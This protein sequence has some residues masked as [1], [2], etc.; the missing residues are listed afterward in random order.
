MPTQNQISNLPFENYLVLNGLSMPDRSKFV[1]D[2]SGGYNVLDYIATRQAPARRIEG[3]DGKF[4]K[5]IMGV[6]VTQAVVAS[7][8]L[9]G[10]VLRVFFT[11]PTYDNFR[12]STVVGNGTANDCMGTVIAHAPGYVDVVPAPP[13]TAWNTSLHFLANS[14]ITEYFPASINRGSNALESQYEYPQYVINQ[15]SIIRDNLQLFRRDLSKTWVAYDGTDIWGTAQ[16]TIMMQR[17]ARSLEYRGLFSYYGTTNDPDGTRNFSMGLKASIKDPSR[18]GVYVASPSL[19][20]EAS[21]NNWI[22]EIADRRNSG[23]TSMTFLVGRGFLSRVQS[24]ASVRTS[25]QYT[26]KNNTFGGES[27]KGLDVYEYS[28]NGINCR[29]IM[30]PI[31]NDRTRFPQLSTISGTGSLTRMSYTGICLDTD[32]YE[33][34]SGEGMLPAVEKVYFGEQETIVYYVPGVWGSNLQGYTGDKFTQGSITAAVNNNDA[35]TIGI[36]SDCAFDFMSYRSGW[37]ELTN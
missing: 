26:G 4:E 19:M 36:Y 17:Y 13:L 25:I 18:G 30:A 12:L 5:P 11:D 34:R 32:M 10:S 35:V 21:F 20:T 15:T 33:S 14:Y 8:Q 28:V 27:V 31:L 6:S 2:L 23:M 24:F 29:F 7:T 3:R 16:D 37:Y 1:Y 22:N 9:N